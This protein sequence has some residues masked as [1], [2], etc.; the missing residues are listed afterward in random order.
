MA[1]RTWTFCVVVLVAACGGKN[2]SSDDDAAVPADASGSDGLIDSAAIDAPTDSPI[3]AMPDAMADAAIDAMPDAMVDAAID[4]MPDAMVDATIDAAID[5]PIDAPIDAAIDAPIDAPSCTSGVTPAFC[6]PGGCTD[7]AIDPLNC[8]Q[9]NMQCPSS[10]MCVNGG[11][12]PICGGTTPDVCNNA[13]TDKQTDENNCGQCGMQCGSGEVCSAGTCVLDCQAPTPDLCGGTTCVDL[14]TDEQHCGMCPITCTG[15]TQCLGGACQCTGVTPDL[16]S[17]TCTNKQTDPNNCGACGAPCGPGTVCS[18]GQC[19]LNCTTPFPDNCSGV[20]TDKLNDSANCGA[21][22]TQCPF[23]GTCTNGACVCPGGVPTTCNGACVNTTND[24]NNCG[25]CGNTCMAGTTCQ[26]GVCCGPGLSGCGTSCLDLQNDVM[27]CGACGNQCGTGESCNAGVCGCPYGETLCNGACIPTAVDPNNCGG[28]GVTCAA[29]QAC[30]SNGCATTCPAPLTK[31]GNQ[32]VDLKTDTAHCGSCNNAACTGNTGCSDG[33]CV[34]VT[35]VGPAPPKCAG[36]GPPIVVPTGGSSTCTGQ[37]GATAFTYALCSRTDIGPLSQ[38][39]TTDAFDSTLGPYVPGM[40]GGSIGVNGTI[41]DTAKLQI[42]GDL[43]V[44][45]AAGLPMKGDI[46]I[47][48]R[49]YDQGPL[50]ISKLLSVE[51]DAFVNGPITASGSGLGSITGVLTT[52]S[53]SNITASLA[54]GSCV[55]APVSVSPPCGTAL[56]VIPV[57]QIVAHFENPANN[58]NAAIGLDKNALA[59]P[60]GATRLDLPCGYYHLTSIGGS[61]PVTIYAHG[62]TALFISGAINSTKPFYMSLDPGATLDVFVGGVVV[63]SQAVSI[64]TPAYP[65]TSR[66]YIGSPSCKGNGGCTA[67]ADCCSGVC[68]AGSC[69]GSGGGLSNSLKLSG[70]STYLNG[71]F[72]AGLGEIRISNPLEMYGAMFANYYEASGPTVVH[73]DNGAITNGEECPPP[74][75]CDGCNDCNNQACV[76]GVC[77]ACTQDSDCCTP[78]RCDSGT[79]KL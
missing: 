61:Q 67:N 49:L 78:L 76:G 57:R 45:G 79:C 46:T 20:C 4:A 55:Q 31:C 2:T 5:A 13:C 68:N 26:G 73:Y 21:C 63:S 44:G 60:S 29:G 48:Q 12:Q 1:L 35:P 15:G 18:A 56:D 54:Y 50:G 69:Q 19:V 75:T 9:C 59:N 33:A 22:G 43:R 39:I 7:L 16:C 32:C 58:D 36:G 37:I 52:P 11:C 17:G 62:R 41:S 47:R 65:R 74:T 72:Y 27:N 24:S 25:G 8:G 42:G 10:T 64:G 30:V 71:L 34:P 14:Q 53:C 28:C 6:T 23:G 3:D 51:E 77:G 70:G 66:V 40:K 38:P